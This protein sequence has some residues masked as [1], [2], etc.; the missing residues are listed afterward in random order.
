L[1]T[2]CHRFQPGQLI[3][4]LGGGICCGPSEFS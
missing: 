4:R 1:V 3:I 2:D